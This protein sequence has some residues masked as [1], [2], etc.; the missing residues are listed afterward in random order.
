MKHLHTLRNSLVAVT[1]A[2][3]MA[4]AGTPA[5]AVDSDIV[6]T[7]SPLFEL[8]GTYDPGTKTTTYDL[9]VT[10]DVELATV[11]LTATGKTSL[12]TGGVF[13]PNEVGGSVLTQSFTTNGKVELTIKSTD[14]AGNNSSVTLELPLKPKHLFRGGGNDY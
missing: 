1:L 10:D 14:A 7:M 9:L 5:Y 11:E 4:L 8:S 3:A 2:G 6:D 13:G 12:G